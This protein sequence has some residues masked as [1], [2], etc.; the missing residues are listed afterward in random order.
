MQAES[1]TRARYMK[2]E[3]DLGNNPRAKNL[4]FI[5][6][7][8]KG[9]ELDRLV[10]NSKIL[11]DPWHETPFG[12]TP[13]QHMALHQEYVTDFDTVT[14]IRQQIVKSGF[15]QPLRID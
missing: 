13:E 11:P 10:E 15:E 6:L 8:E 5:A 14:S 2:I 12:A 3:L 9:L 4:L 7:V 1:V